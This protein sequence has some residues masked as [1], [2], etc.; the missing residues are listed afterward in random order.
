MIPPV[1]LPANSKVRIPVD[2]KLKPGWRLDPTHG[3]FET[4]S[5]ERF[6]PHKDLPKNSR[7]VYKVPGLAGADPSKLSKHE[8]D[9]QR[10]VQVILPPGESPADYVDLIRKWPCV[11]EAHTAPEMS[12]PQ[13]G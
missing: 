3:F 2:L 1:T 7:I 11:A 4:D 10:Y 13:H 12:L 9:L 5:G 8:R 6:T